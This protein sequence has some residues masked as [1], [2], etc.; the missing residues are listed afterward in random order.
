M[1]L[2]IPIVK[3]PLEPVTVQLLFISTQTGEEMPL[4]K[5]TSPSVDSLLEAEEPLSEVQP[6]MI[7]QFQEEV[8]RLHSP[9]CISLHAIISYHQWLHILSA[10]AAGAVQ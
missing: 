2:V 7:E 5:V 1:G 3:F 9:L 4:N 6:E 8:D 10:A